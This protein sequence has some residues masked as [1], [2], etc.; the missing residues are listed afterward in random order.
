[1]PPEAG[2]ERVIKAISNPKI[3]KASCLIITAS[4]ND[5]VHQKGGTGYTEPIMSMFEE[6][7]V[8]VKEKTDKSIF[9]GLAP[10]LQL[11]REAHSKA[12]WINK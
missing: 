12:V 10:R 2:L 4:G 8:K 9:V 5:L 11:S 1:V 3:E 7:A 6:I